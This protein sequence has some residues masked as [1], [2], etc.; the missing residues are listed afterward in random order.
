MIAIRCLL[1]ACALAFT[2]PGSQA[3]SAPLDA[4][5]AQL[6]TSPRV[7]ALLIERGGKLTF[8]HYRAD[9]T[10]ATLVNIASVTKS[11]TSILVGIAADRGLLRIDEPLAAFFPEYAQGP[12]A[13]KLQRVTLR[14]L[15]TLSPGFDRGG[16]SADADYNDFLQRFYSPGLLQHALGR[17]LASEPGSRFA[18][19]NLDAQLVAAALSRRLNV[20]LKDF[21][22]D[23]LFRPL[24]IGTFEW[25]ASA[26]G[27]PEGAA[28]LRLAAP[29][30]LRMGRMM[31]DG[32]A[33]QGRQVVSKHYVEEA[34]T[35]H[36]ATDVP[37]RGP[38]KL[39]GYGYLWWTSSTQGDDRP[40]FYAAGYGGQFIY[41]VPSLDVV[42]VAVTEPVSREVAARTATLVRDYALPAAR[43]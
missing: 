26:D 17:P 12:D 15:L 27:N 13:G 9:T 29:D 28:G 8:E 31:L 38:A 14:H 7:R 3:Q 43:P 23:E 37:P 35:R 4:L 11:V 32:G 41:V 24:G 10:S 42:I 6:R 22:R 21:A 25:S 18:Y 2:A 30:L 20:P 34:T 39:W 40:A 33:W 36:I 1:F 5:Q 16:L 19:S